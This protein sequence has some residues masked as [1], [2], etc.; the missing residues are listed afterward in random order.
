MAST[1]IERYSFVA[2][3]ELLVGNQSFSIAQAAPEFLILSRPEQV[4]T[5]PAELMIR[6]CDE[7]TPVRRQIQVLGPVQGDPLRISIRR[8]E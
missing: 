6:Y 5:G 2:T 8:P 1:S 7:P 3:G 4:P